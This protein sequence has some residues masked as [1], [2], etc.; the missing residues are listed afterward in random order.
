M[1]KVGELDHVILDCDYEFENTSKEGLVVK[2]FFENDKLV[3]QWI[4]GRKP[5][6]AGQAEKYIDLTYR[7]SDDPYTQYRAMKL[8]DPGIDLTGNYKC[9][10][11]TYDDED[12]AY[13]SMVIYG[14]RRVR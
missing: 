1:V 3:Y 10:I 5:L 4:Y 11:S 6:A 8:N 12:A 7:A 9:V 2:W 13:A 14:E